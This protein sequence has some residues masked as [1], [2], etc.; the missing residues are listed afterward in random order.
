MLVD[1]LFRHQYGK[2][3]AILTR[4][5]GLQQIELIEDALQETFAKATVAWR[6]KIPENPEAWLT[7]VAKNKAVDLL[8]SQIAH[9]KRENLFSYGSSVAHLDELFGE[10]EAEDSQLMLIF[11]AC[12]PELKA[13]DQIAFALRTLSG[14]SI[15]EVAS[16]LLTSEENI[17]KRLNRA[18]GTIRSLGI[19]FEFP[20]TLHLDD[21]MVA[22]LK[23]IYLIFNEGFHSA[24]TSQI[25][26]EDLCGE[27]LR[28]CKLILKQPHLR[29]GPTYALFALMCLHSARLSSKTGKSGEIIDLENQDRSQ[30]YVPLVDLGMN[31]LRKSRSYGIPSQYLYEAEIAAEHVKAASFAETDWQRILGWYDCLQRGAADPF[32]QINRALVLLKSGNHKE[33]KSILDGIRPSDL[34]RREYLLHGSHAEYHIAKGAIDE[35]ARCLNVALER[36][37]HPAEKAFLM[38]KRNSLSVGGTDRSVNTNL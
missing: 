17:K 20:D 3:V 36:A 29:S 34:G 4:I 6:T 11:V 26:R 10:R 22:V 7:Q 31:A 28:L 5:F 35:A 23:V 24:G 25:V 30:W 19:R 13:Q 38:K 1:H 33:A 27:A 9:Q 2:M 32:L 21:R 18:R 12:H 16:A 37:A 15:G 14:F 8:R